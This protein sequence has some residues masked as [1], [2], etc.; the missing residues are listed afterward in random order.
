MRTGIKFALSVGTLLAMMGAANADPSISL[1]AVVVKGAAISGSGQ[2]DTDGK[3]FKSITLF[4][5]PKSGGVAVQNKITAAPNGAKGAWG[6]LSVSTTYQT[7]YQV[8]AV[9]VVTDANN[10]DS[11]YGSVVSESTVNQGMTTVPTSNIVWSDLQQPTSNGATISGAGTWTQVPGATNVFAMWIWP[12]A[13]GQMAFATPTV[14]P[15]KKPPSWSA[16]GTGALGVNTNVS[17]I[18]TATITGMDPI[19]YTAPIRPI[20]P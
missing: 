2:Y 15:T 10:N 1:D 5:A 14:D 16:S 3:T 4:A 12:A 13:G 17:P 7:T 19:I 6:P 11:Y 18:Y 20:K 9:L 8:W